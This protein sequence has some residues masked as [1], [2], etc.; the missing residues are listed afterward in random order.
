M[1][2]LN[3]SRIRTAQDRFEREYPPDALGSAPD[4]FRVAAPVSLA[5]DIFKDKQQF[6][7]V[8]RV[9]TTLELPCSRCLEP[10]DWPVDAEFDLR[11][12]P[13]AEAGV[14]EKGEREIDDGDLA[15]AFYV[16]DEI[17]LVQL[18]HEQ[19]YLSLP[20][21]P[22]H[23]EACKGLCPVCGTNWN[24]ATCDCNTQWED[25]RLAA[26]KALKKES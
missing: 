26:L 3:L 10:F 24:R 20:M 15:A 8:G 17:D 4:D 19:F 22:L 18:M 13:Q 14:P 25:P 2:A 23:S 11:Y 16:N 7:L 12:L 5:F 9:K 1:L 6:R 21:K